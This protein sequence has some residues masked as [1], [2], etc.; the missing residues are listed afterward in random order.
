MYTF[1]SQP[2]AKGV[3]SFEGL[4]EQSEHTEDS[5]GG[6]NLCEARACGFYRIYSDTH[7]ESSFKI[8]AM[9]LS[10]PR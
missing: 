10:G 5:Q 7:E 9:E 1:T 2:P 6:A 4:I 3:G 8:E